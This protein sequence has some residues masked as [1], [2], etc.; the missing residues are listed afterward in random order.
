MEA[1]GAVL[2]LLGE[3]PLRPLPEDPEVFVGRTM[4]LPSLH[5]QSGVRVDMVFSFTPYEREA[6]A[7][8]RR[9]PLGG[10]EVRFASPEDLVVHKI[11]AGRPRDLEDV[12]TVVRNQPGLDRELVRRC[13]QEFDAGAGEPTFA[14][15]FEAILCTAGA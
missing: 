6:I 13:L 9:V 10:S 15:R 3:V 1:L 8:A 2:G 11:F 12:A 5:G 14:A 7:R 4:A